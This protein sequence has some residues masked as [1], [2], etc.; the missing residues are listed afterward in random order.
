MPEGPRASFDPDW[1]TQTFP[2]GML[3]VP[4]SQMRAQGFTAGTTGHV[5]WQEVLD[6]PKAAGK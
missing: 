6:A 5:F 4:T 2:Q 1:G 3:G